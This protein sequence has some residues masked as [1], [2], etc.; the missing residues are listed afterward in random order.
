MSP[1]TLMHD[2]SA[3]SFG[4][5]RM[6]VRCVLPTASVRDPQSGHSRYSKLLLSHALLSSLVWMGVN[7]VVRRPT[8]LLSR[9]GKHMLLCI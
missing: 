6:R 9:S 1:V 4:S 7:V 5:Q 2:S 8:V 3:D